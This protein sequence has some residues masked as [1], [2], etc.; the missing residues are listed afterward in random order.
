MLEA[1]GVWELGL[2]LEANGIFLGKRS[3]SKI[4]RSTRLGGLQI[5]GKKFLRGGKRRQGVIGEKGEST[6]PNQHFY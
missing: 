5:V 6:L 1:P 2:F 4:S 3:L